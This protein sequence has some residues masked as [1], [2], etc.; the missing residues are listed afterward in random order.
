TVAAFKG[1]FLAVGGFSFA[2]NVLLLVPA[3]YMLQVYD[4]VLSSRN[5]VTLYMLTLIMAGLFLLEAALEFVRSRVLIRAGAA[6]D[7]RLN[8]RVFDASFQ[9]YLRGRGG[10]PARAFGDLTN[11]RQFLGGK[12]LLAFFD[13]PWTPVF[14]AVIFLLHPWLGLF[15]L[16]AA[17]ILF[18]LA[19]VNQ[20]ATGPGLAEASRLAQAA[21]SY[22][23]SNMRNA[24]VIEAMGMLPNLHRRWFARQS[25]SLAAQA[26]ASDRAAVVNAATKFFRMT[27]QSGILGTG[28]LLVINNQL[29]P[30]GMIAASILLG[31]ALSPVDLL[32]TTWRSFVSA[33]GAYAK[34]SELL[35][36]HPARGAATSLPRPG[37]FVA[38]QNLVVAAPGSRTPTLKGVSFG[39]A[40]GM[41]VAVIGP[42][43]SGKSTL[44][45]ALVGVWAPLSGAVRLDSADVHAWNKAELGPWIGYLPQD[46]E[47]F[48]GTIAENIARFGE[49]DS[50]RIVQAAQRAGVHELILHLPQGYDTPIGEGGMVLSGGQRQRVALARALYGDPALVVLDEPNANLDEAGDAA[51]IAALEAMREEKRTVVVMTHRMNLVR[52]ADAVMVL[53]EGAIQAYGPRETV[54]KSLPRRPA[55]PVV[56]ASPDARLP[57]ENA[58]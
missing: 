44:A 24:E 54:L 18:A 3:L 25:G 9:R 12:G 36:A 30:G 49:G 32:I 13:A 5:E 42:S 46:V 53:A 14:I 41:L 40:P 11:I 15:A 55:R 27:L 33:K 7:L 51:L 48:E 21:N 37:G 57:R 28:A 43:A 56:V 16:G 26:Q 45:R 6:L 31:R 47:L 19:Y 52:A 1:V 29:T 35:A 34:L 10:D 20:R 8:A 17:L 4:R 58:A 50:V 2:I 39:A 22:A 23:A 38:A